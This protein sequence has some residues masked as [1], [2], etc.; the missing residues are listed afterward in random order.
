MPTTLGIIGCGAIFEKFYT[1]AITSLDTSRVKLTH[2]VDPNLNRIN[3]FLST[4]PDAQTFSNLEE[5]INTPPDGLIIATP[6]G[7]HEE[8]AIAAI[9]A[10]THAFI[11]KPLAHTVDSA[12]R[13]VEAT[14]SSTAVIGV[15]MFRRFWPALQWIKDTIDS[16]TLGPLLNIEHQEGGPFDWP[17]AS[18]SFFEP[19]KAGGGVL[20]DIGVHVLD[21]L[22]WWLGRPKI[23]NYW[24]DAEGGLEANCKLELEFDGGTK[25]DVFL[26]RDWKT[27][28]QM[29]LQFENA[30]VTWDAGTVNQIKIRPN[31]STYWLRADLESE[32]GGKCLP[33]DNYQ[34]SFTRQLVSFIEAIEGKRSVEVTPSEALTTLAVI[35]ECYQTLRQ[36]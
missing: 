22:V 1:P 26:S 14:S 16:Q 13:I 27:R 24:D 6:S 28:N 34:Q 21:T 19:K 3:G 29:V 15:A 18:T 7:M 2:L 35:D 25:A 10:G 12:R 32:T 36:N 11:E 31:G 5:A 33:A 4:F 23:E 17:A 30:L 8:H 20:L 9:A